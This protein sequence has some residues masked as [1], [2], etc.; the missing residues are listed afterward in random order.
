MG[1]DSCRERKLAHVY[2]QPTGNVVEGP[3][4]TAKSLAYRPSKQML[5]LLQSFGFDRLRLMS[6]GVRFRAQAI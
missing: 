1:G 5:Y 6:V 4:G 3:R 2:V